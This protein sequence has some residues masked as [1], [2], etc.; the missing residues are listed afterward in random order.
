M[1]AGLVRKERGWLFVKNCVFHESIIL[2]QDFADVPL[3]SHSAIDVLLP[4]FSIRAC[5]GMKW[6]ELTSMILSKMLALQPAIG[7]VDGQRSRLSGQE[8]VQNE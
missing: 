2:V 7:P 3:F 5:C 1:G 8:R 4:A 6:F